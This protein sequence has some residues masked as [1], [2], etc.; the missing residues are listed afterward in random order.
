MLAI[1][2]FII[3]YPEPGSRSG[4]ILNAIFSRTDLLLGLWHD[5]Q[6]WVQPASENSVGSGHPSGVPSSAAEF[7]REKS[8]H[9]AVAL[10]LLG[11]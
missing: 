2:S 1:A 7:R 6:G 3:H 8:V 11:R 9:E 5:T 10:S 4:K